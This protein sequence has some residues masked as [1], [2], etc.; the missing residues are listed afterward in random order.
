MVV[1]VT[2]ALAG[3]KYDTRLV[4]Q[5]AQ[6]VHNDTKSVRAMAFVDHTVEE[7]AGGIAGDTVAEAG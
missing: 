2:V 5:Q 4:L 3:I 7:A 6:V 1:A